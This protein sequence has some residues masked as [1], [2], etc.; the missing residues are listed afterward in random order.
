LLL[1]VDML[2]AVSARTQPF[3]RHSRQVI[4]QQYQK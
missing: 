4:M 1:Y 3:V 2:G